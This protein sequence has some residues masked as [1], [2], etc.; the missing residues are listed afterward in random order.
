MGDEDKVQLVLSG[1]TMSNDD[2]ACI[3]VKN[4][5][6]VFITLAEGTTNTLSDAGK[7]YTETDKDSTV[8]GVI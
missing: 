4:A 5:D 6:K 3:F 2:S 7:E 1:V 8:D